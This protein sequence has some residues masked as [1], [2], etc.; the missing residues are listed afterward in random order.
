[1]LLLV[2]L[3]LSLSAVLLFFSRCCRC[4]VMVATVVAVVAAA[5]VVGIAVLQKNELCWSFDPRKCISAKIYS[6]CKYP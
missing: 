5:V 4:T 3:W 1:M 6:K 2:L